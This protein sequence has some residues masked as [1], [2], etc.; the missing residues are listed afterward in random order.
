MPSIRTFIAF[1]TPSPIK[2]EMKQLQEEL[3][4]S[5]A[6]VKWESIDKFHAT[7]KF[8]GDV[9]ESILQQVLSTTE[10][11]LQKY[12]EFDVSYQS[13]GCFPNKKHPRIIWIGCDNHDGKL[14]DIKNTLDKELAA[15]GFEIE[16][17][18]FH[19]H[20]TLGRVKGSR[21]LNNLTPMLE[22]LTFEPHKASINEILII[23]ST[24]KPEGSVYST[25]KM[26]RLNP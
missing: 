1:D 6:D 25:L 3:K 9:E 2:N 22:N 23:K 21:G 26:I 14:A 5:C 7:I 16:H 13:L 8:L 18:T 4:N 10:S 12:S 19:P 15:Y 11:I 20:I 24:L 17:R